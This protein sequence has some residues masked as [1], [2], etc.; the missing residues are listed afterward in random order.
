MSYRV[1]VG[2]IGTVYD[3]PDFEKAEGYGRAAHK[4]VTLIRSHD[5]EPVDAY[6]PPHFFDRH[7]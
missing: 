1:T 5:D 2:D 7:L 4:P 3:G 6:Y